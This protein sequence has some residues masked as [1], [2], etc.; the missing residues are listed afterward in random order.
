MARGGARVTGLDSEAPGVVGAV[1]L[2]S[3]EK[4]DC[5]VGEGWRVGGQL[6]WSD[7]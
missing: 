6:E 3:F 5:S 2:I 4:N 1:G 7:Q